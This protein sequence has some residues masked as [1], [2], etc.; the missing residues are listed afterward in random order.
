MTSHGTSYHKFK[1]R[2]NKC[3]NHVQSNTLDVHHGKHLK[4]HSM[5]LLEGFLHKQIFSCDW[6][7]ARRWRCIIF[8]ELCWRLR[9][10]R[11]NKLILAPT[12][13]IV[14]LANKKTSQKQCWTELESLSWGTCG[15]VDHA[16]TNVCAEAS[17][18]LARNTVQSLQQ[19]RIRCL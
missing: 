8:R 4:N 14:N 15:R 17:M 5:V 18:T 11:E 7:F 13:L 16:S 12:I 9:F 2:A 3:E 1:G 6:R 19:F 10:R